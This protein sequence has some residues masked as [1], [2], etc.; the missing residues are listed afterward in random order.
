VQGNEDRPNSSPSETVFQNLQ[1]IDKLLLPPK[2]T[3]ETISTIYRCIECSELYHYRNVLKKHVE[4]GHLPDPLPLTCVCGR[5]VCSRDE[6]LLC[7]SN[8]CMDK[9][10]LTATEGEDMQDSAYWVVSDSQRRTL[11][12]VMGSFIS[13]INQRFP[14]L[15]HKLIQ[16][17]AR[18]QL[19][20]F[21]RVIGN[22]KEHAQAL[23]PDSCQ[24]GDLCFLKSLPSLI[25]G[26]S[27]DKAIINAPSFSSTLAKLP[28]VFECPYC[29]Q[30]RVF[31]STSQWRDHIFEDMQLFDCTFPDCNGCLNQKRW[32]RHVSE[33]HHQSDRKWVCKHAD[34]TFST[35]RKENMCLHL[36]RHTGT[37]R[38]DTDSE[39][40][41]IHDKDKGPC[42]FCGNFSRTLKGLRNHLMEHMSHIT[43]I[44]L[45]PDGEL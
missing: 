5:L 14:G 23:E 1:S 20:Q 4:K 15:A 10:N 28:A 19:R 40:R 45:G 22:M 41:Y 13:R 6:Y 32:L 30:I 34:C 9:A 29:L 39:H 2:S 26:A 3:A 36:V 35:Y 43:E 31:K 38:L 42:C 7:F 18:S 8:H 25:V 33:V 12:N 27:Q 17:L 44:L 24:A 37:C 16:R 21:G 11:E